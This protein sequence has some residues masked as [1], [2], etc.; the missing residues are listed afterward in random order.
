MK[1]LLIGMLAISSLFAQS[2]QTEIQ[3]SFL[4]LNDED[5][6]NYIYTNEVL[7]V[8]NPALIQV[9]VTTELNKKMDDYGEEASE[10][11]GDTILGGPFGITND[12]PLT[13]VDS[14]FVQDDNLLAISAVVRKEAVFTDSRGCEYDEEIDNWNDS[15][16]PGEITEYFYLDFTGQ[17]IEGNLNSDFYFF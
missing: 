9:L 5:K 16:E 11:W 14:I 13:E 15:C 17:Y 7:E 1:I 8:F 4:S 10:I 2:T 3:N 12:I 6:I